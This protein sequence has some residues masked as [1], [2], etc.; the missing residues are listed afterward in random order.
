MEQGKASPQA[1]MGQGTAAPQAADLARRRCLMFDFDGTLADSRPAIVSTARLVLSQ[2]GMSEREMGDL[3][4]LV[5]PPFPAAFTQIYGMSEADALEVASRYRTEFAKLGKARHPIF[6][7]IKELLADARAEGRRVAL[8]SSKTRVRALEMLEAESMTGLFDAI[9]C[10]LDPSRADK[11]HLVE[12]TLAELGA[13]A[14]DAV[15]VGDR[16]YDVEGALANGVP[17]VGVTYGHTSKPGEL[18]GAGAAVV[19]GSVA[20]L[21]GVLLG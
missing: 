15:M 6:P 8:T 3:D 14:S 20:V 2:W 17:C 5:G 16:F 1:G 18:E 13:E 21:R 7:G 4:R 9:V 12:D 10:Q 11:T 19:V